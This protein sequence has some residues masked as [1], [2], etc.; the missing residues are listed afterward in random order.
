MVAEVRSGVSLLYESY[1]PKHAV[2]GLWK[3]HCL[4]LNPIFQSLE[5][6]RSSRPLNSDVAHNLEYC[7]RKARPYVLY[8]RQQITGRRSESIAWHDGIPHVAQQDVSPGLTNR[9]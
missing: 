8:D 2:C 7:R 3:R 6:L 1:R 4:Q 9:Q 5:L